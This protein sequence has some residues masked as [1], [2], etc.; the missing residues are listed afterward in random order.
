MSSRAQTCCGHPVRPFTFF[1]A[2]NDSCRPSVCHSKNT[3]RYHQQEATD[4]PRSACLSLIITTFPAT[5]PTRA[6]RGDQLHHVV[7]S[8]SGG[9][10]SSHGGE[11]AREGCGAATH[12]S[13]ALWGALTHLRGEKCC[14]YSTPAAHPCLQ[15]KPIGRCCS[16]C[17]GIKG[18]LKDQN[19]PGNCLNIQELGLNK[20]T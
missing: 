3:P 5:A 6:A 4:E 9:V 20:S 17:L 19:P 12:T 7:L 1:S 13:G 10:S 8:Q 14:F 11:D 18:D 16:K 15:L 2:P